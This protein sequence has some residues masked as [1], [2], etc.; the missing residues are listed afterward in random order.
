MAPRDRTLR[1]RTASVRFT[2]PAGPARGAALVLPGGKVRSASRARRWQL[3]VARMRPFARQLDEQ[4]G[5]L[6]LAVGTVLYRMRGWN[7]AQAAPVADVRWA[8]EQVRIRYGPVPVVLV[9][10]SMGGRTALRCAGDASVVAVVALAPWL[11]QGE[12]VEQLRGRQLLIVHG[13]QDRWTDPGASRLYSRAAQPVAA[14]GSYVQVR[15]DGHPMLRRAGTWHAL[16]TAF[17]LRVLGMRT[18]S[19]PASNDLAEGVELAL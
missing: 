15:G 12:P 5:D 16:T 2:D 18:D 4:G 14:G 1:R 9:G 8:L 3:A 11:E 7:G 10:H 19:D 13:D 17:V 6:G